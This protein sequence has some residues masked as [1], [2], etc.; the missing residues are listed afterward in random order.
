MTVD[1]QMN[2][3]VLNVC[4]IILLSYKERMKYATYSNMD[5]CRDCHTY[6]SKPDTERQICYITYMWYL[7]SGTNKLIYKTEIES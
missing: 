2:K 1:R 5:G 4:H 6:W 3:N 7:K